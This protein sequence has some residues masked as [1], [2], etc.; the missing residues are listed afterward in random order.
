MDS[1][2]ENNVIIISSNG[3]N[4]QNNY[5]RKTSPEMTHKL[6]TIIKECDF[7]SNENTLIKFLINKMIHIFDIQLSEHRIKQLISNAIE[8]KLIVLE[9]D[10]RFCL[11]YDSICD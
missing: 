8:D 10:N 4:D 3:S 1:I 2:N 7:K 6:W 11:R 9:F 5:Y